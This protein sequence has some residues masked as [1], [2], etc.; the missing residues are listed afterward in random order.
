[1][2]ALQNWYAYFIDAAVIF[3]Q[4]MKHFYYLPYQ[5]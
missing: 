5:S 3:S 1:M 2:V 4:N